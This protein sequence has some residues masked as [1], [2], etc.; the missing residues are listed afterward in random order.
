[1]NSR[2][3]IVVS[4][5]VAAVPAFGHDMPKGP[6]GG[7]VVEA[8]DYHVELVAQN[9]M[10]DVFLMDGSDKPM[11]LDG[12]KGLAILVIGGK[13]ARVVLEPVAG[14]LTGKAAGVPADVKGV[15]RITGPRGQTAQA[16]FR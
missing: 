16:K 10:V 5:L 3:I 11:P 14:H 12:V 7:R 15:V 13:S 6:N 9:N 4:A 8:G 1:M 2:A